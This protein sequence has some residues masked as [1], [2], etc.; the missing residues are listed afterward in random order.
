MSASARNDPLSFYACTIASF[1][2]TSVGTYVEN[3]QPFFAH[4]EGRD[5]TVHCGELFDFADQLS[6]HERADLVLCMGDTLTHLEAPE[7]VG[8]LSRAVAARLSPRGR[9]PVRADERRILT[10]PLPGEPW[11]PS[12]A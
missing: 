2:E 10:S 1:L 5:V 4:A 8:A 7:A 6:T 11:A 9:F 3:L 12:G